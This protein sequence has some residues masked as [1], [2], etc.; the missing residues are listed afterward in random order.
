MY[1]TMAYDA[2]AFKYNNDIKYNFKFPEQEDNAR[3]RENL[4]NKKR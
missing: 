1:E 4:R 2:D 3:T